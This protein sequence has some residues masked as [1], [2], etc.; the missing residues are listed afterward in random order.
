MVVWFSF[1]NV[2]TSG[3][4]LTA[5]EGLDQVVSLDQTTARCVH[6]DAF[7]VMRVPR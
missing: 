3:S 1:V 4:D 2:K 7:S 6:D 5:L